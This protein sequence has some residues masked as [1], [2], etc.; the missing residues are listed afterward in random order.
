[1]DTFDPDTITQDK[2]HELRKAAEDAWGDDTRHPDFV[3]HPEPSAGQCYV[4]SRWLADRLGGHVGTKAGH[5]FWVSPDKQYV[6]DLTGDQYAYKPTDP[7]VAGQPLDAEDEPWQLQKD[8]DKHRPGPIMYVPADHPV[9]K[10][11]RIK[12]DPQPGQDRRDW[13]DLEHP[14]APVTNRATLFARRANQALSGKLQ[15][16]AD[17]GGIGSDAYPGS[18]PQFDEDFQDRYLHDTLSDLLL[19]QEKPTPHEY[20]WFFGNGQ[21][22]VSPVHS[23]DELR[24]HSG[25]PANHSGPVGAGYVNVEGR[26]ATWSVESNIA[27]R[28][29]TKRLRDYSK[30]VGWDWGG[31]VGG[32]GQPIHEDFGSKKSFWY[33]WKGGVQIS[34]SPL[35]EASRIDVTGRTARIHG[36]RHLGATEREALEE[37]A[38]DFGY[39]IAEYPGGGNMTDKIKTK[40]WPTTFDR[41]NPDKGEAEPAFEGVPQGELTC[42][43]CGT[44]LPNYME[45]VVHTEDHKAQDH[46][47]IEDGHFPTLNDMDDPLPIR[48]RNPEPVAMPLGSYHE[49]SAVEDFDL[50]ANLWGFHDD[51]RH[52]FYGGY[53]GGQ[54]VGYG[55]VKLPDFEAGALPEVTMVYSSVRNKGVGTAILAKI[56]QQWPELRTGVVS[57]E[58]ERLA[59]KL[60]F[61]EV[62][63]GEWRHAQGQEQEG[64]DMI[65]AP[66]PFVYDIDK[67]YITVGHPGQRTTEI[68][69]MFT[70]GGIVEGYYEPGGVLAINSNTTVPYTINHLVQLWYWSHPKLEVT[71]VEMEREGGKRQKLAGLDAG[72]YVKTLMAADPAAWNAFQALRREGGHVYIVGGAPRDALLGKTPKDIDLMV[73]GLPEE[74]VE[75]ILGGLPGRVEVTG[76]KF[77]VF[78]YHTKG[79]EVEIALPRTDQYEEGGRRGT[80]TITV[81][82]TLP[83]EK[84]LERRDFTA[85]SMAV[86]AE[87]GHLLDPFGGA[88]DIERGVLR[89]THANS[90]KEDPTRLLRAITFSSRFGLTPDEKTRREIEENA[91][92]LDQESPD[93]LK[94]QLEKLMTSPNPAGALRIARETGLLRHLFPELDENFDYDQNN[95]HHNFSLGEHSFNVL[96]NVSRITNDA[97]VRLAALLHDTG[98]PASAW[99]HPETGETHYY[100]GDIDGHPVGDNHWTVG[101]NLAEKRLRETY[102]YPVASIRKVHGLIDNH[103]FPAFSSSKGARKFLHKYE[104]YCDDLLTLREGDM[105]GKGQS[106]DELAARTSIDTMRG[107]T[108][109]ARQVQ[110][111]TN[112]SMIAINGNDLLDLGL[113]P[114]P[115]VGTV[116]RQL[117]NDVVDDPTLNDPEALKQRAQEYIQALPS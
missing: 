111:P 84:D 94:Q 76:K 107:L 63:A 43:F 65:Q 33:R 70:P 59:R 64:K 55:V 19:T 30:T 67:D 3:G 88:K 109:N 60:G 58:G 86:D 81:D 6:I 12:S 104:P 105:N 51:D 25:T 49:A 48:I 50:Y 24:D 22:H 72:S 91:Y 56:L 79:Q 69:G 95:T 54:L 44:V 29:L 115:Q 7:R 98:K 20:Q 9:Y 116:L 96:D 13:E 39:R 15:R 2:L 16:H 18:E 114:G 1:M 47:E 82:H 75:R 113:K 52:A 37:W 108:E 100:R 106:Q 62:T 31:L 11:F 17:S 10:D 89:T 90:F 38:S 87:T 5:Y 34:A 45:Y 101:A 8:H 112:Q 77:G 103:M 110:A 26:N 68:P 35:R 78:R 102:N 99:T 66:I 117:T 28:G 73:G 74:S 21:L 14:E 85:N 42:P 93:A 41:G 36:S 97:D 46:G 57:D 23:H 80:G 61:V 83:V 40:E 92:R 32:D 71:K 4:T 27:L 53:L